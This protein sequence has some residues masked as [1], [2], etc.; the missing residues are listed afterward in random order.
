VLAHCEHR[1]LPPANGRQ[2][3]KRLTNSPAPDGRDVTRWTERH[4]KYLLHGI[5]WTGG[6]PVDGLPIA[7]DP[8]VAGS[9]PSPAPPAKALVDRKVRQG[10][11]RSGAG[12]GGRCQRFVNARIS[13]PLSRCFARVAVGVIRRCCQRRL[14]GATSSRRI[15]AHACDAAPGGAVGGQPQR[16]RRRVRWRSTSLRR[17][18]SGACARALVACA[19]L[20]ATVAQ[21]FRE[22]VAVV[23]SP[24]R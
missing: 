9:N 17:C 1:G 15:S 6:H 3:P 18:G 11:L 12:I 2:L 13:V 24:P 14:H 16:G 8:K 5:R 4:A 20:L 21:V 7:H 19:T 23:A 22:V 10:F